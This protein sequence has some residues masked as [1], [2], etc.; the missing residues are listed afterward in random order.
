METSGLSNIPN[1]IY[2]KI[3]ENLHQRENHPIKLI[4]DRIYEY[5]DS[6][7]IRHTFDDLSSQV[8]T[9]ENFDYLLIPKDHPARKKTDTYYV[10]DTHV[11]ALETIA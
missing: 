11:C 10:D 2:K 7:G 9:T 3:G 6:V 5:F 1:S 8:T 4:K